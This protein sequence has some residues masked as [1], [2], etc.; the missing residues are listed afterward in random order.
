MVDI[1]NS[2]SDAIYMKWE[3][4]PDALMCYAHAIAAV[5]CSKVGVGSRYAFY[6]L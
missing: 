1:R 3:R 2:F 5:G 4:K 6:T